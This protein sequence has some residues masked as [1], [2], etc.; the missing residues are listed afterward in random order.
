MSKNM[1]EQLPFFE[2]KALC[3][4]YL[5]KKEYHPS[6]AAYVK[7]L[8]EKLVESNLTDEQVDEKV[9]SKSKHPRHKVV[10]KTILNEIK[11]VVN[12]AMQNG[13]GG[14]KKAYNALYHAFDVKYNTEIMVS[15][16]QYATSQNVS[17]L[18]I[19]YVCDIEQ[20]GE[21]LLEVAKEIFN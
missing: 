20:K 2:L 13:A 8:N 6:I 16:K 4:N 19:E 10:N 14:Y 7:R 21:E 12:K 18:V 9:K 17:I 5:S 1:Y 11:D 3:A 15:A